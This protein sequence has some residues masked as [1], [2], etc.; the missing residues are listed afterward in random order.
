MKAITITRKDFNKALSIAVE[1]STEDVKK[2]DGS[3]MAGF[4]IPMTGVIF[5]REIEN[6]LFGDEEDPN[7][8]G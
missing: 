6:A 4:L 5:S 8:E 2:Y 1:K 7:Q 3:P